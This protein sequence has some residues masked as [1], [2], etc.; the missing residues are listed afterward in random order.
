MLRRRY[1]RKTSDDLSGFTLVE[2]LIVLIL[3]GMIFS[4]VIP[5]LSSVTPPYRMRT[6]A[7]KIGGMIEQ[8]RVVSII[9]GRLTGI[10]YVLSGEDKQFVETIPPATPEFPDEPLDERKSLIKHEA[11]DDVF[12]REI[13]LPNG[14]VISNGIVNI[15]FASNGTTGS[16]IIV[17]ETNKETAVPLTLFLKFNSISGILDYY[18]HEVDFQHEYD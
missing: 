8:M 14:Q 15:G 13:K 4:F 2:L 6:Y 16:H 12:I 18:K 7:R 5:N 1:V 11:P 9:R 10:R 3:M 17:L